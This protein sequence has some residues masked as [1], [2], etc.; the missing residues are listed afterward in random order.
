MCYTG[1]TV[2]VLY[3]TYMLYLGPIIATNALITCIA[4]LYL[5]VHV[6]TVI[7]AKRHSELL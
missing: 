7:M 4:R 3:Y 6:L 2:R 5:H 1:C